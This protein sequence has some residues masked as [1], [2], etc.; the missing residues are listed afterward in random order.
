MYILRYAEY[1]IYGKAIINFFL[2]Y[3][4]AKYVC[5]YGITVYKVQK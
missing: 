4:A 5:T 2:L 1:D 3:D